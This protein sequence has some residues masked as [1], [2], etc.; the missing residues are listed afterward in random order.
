MNPITIACPRPVFRKLT[1]TNLDTFRVLADM[2]PELW[3]IQGRVAQG[4]AEAGAVVLV[5]NEA[6]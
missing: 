5:P 6:P 2:F 3:A 4:L 1:V